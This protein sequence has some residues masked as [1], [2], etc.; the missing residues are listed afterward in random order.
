MNNTE[1]VFEY[2]CMSAKNGM[3]IAG[4][5]EVGAA[6]GLAKNRVNGHIKSLVG[7]G[8]ISVIRRKTEYGKDLSKLIFICEEQ[9]RDV[10]VPFSPA[11]LFIEEKDLAG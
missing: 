3:V 1:R 8:R 6:L 2:L 7:S 10:L 9:K 11:L 4:S 5:N